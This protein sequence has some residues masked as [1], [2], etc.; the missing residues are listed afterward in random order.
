MNSIKLNA[1]QD[2]ELVRTNLRPEVGREPEGQAIV[3]A[4][5]PNTS[6]APDGIKDVIQVSDRATT[7]RSLVE[8]AGQLPDIRSER[9]EQLRALV[10]AGAYR[11]DA[12]AIA[13]ALL[14]SES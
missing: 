3:P 9:V 2:I 13:D 1:T 6:P 8:R 4:E 7:I 5:T 11:P 14:K 12:A 10:Q